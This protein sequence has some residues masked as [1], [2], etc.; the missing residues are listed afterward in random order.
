M[1]ISPARCRAACALLDMDHAGGP[2]M[3]KLELPLRTDTKPSLAALYA[4][5]PA[6][7]CR[8]ANGRSPPL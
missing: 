5:Y 2:T 1:S 7:S 6:R 8:S 4:R 3:D